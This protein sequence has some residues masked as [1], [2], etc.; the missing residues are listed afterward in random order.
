MARRRTAGTA[1]RKSSAADR[2]S[3]P[4]APIF[5]GLPRGPHGLDPQQVERHQ[6]A[7]LH[8]AMIEAVLASGY[9]GA[10][11][12]QVIGLAGVSRRSFYE[13]FSDK[14]GCYLAT[15]DLIAA[16]IVKRIDDAHRPSGEDLDDLTAA[17]GELAA[18]VV[19]DPKGAN[20]LFVTT[21]TAGAPG[22]MRLHRAMLNIEQVLAS[23]LTDAV[24]PTLPPRPVLRAIVGGLAGIIG[25]WLRKPPSGDPSR[26]TKRLLAWTSLYLSPST[27]SVTQ[28][29]TAGSLASGR[30]GSRI[31]NT[32]QENS[33]ATPSTGERQRLLDRILALAVETDY[34]SLSVVEI[35]DEASV[36]VDTFFE[37]F[38]SKDACF[39]AGLDMVCDQLRSRVGDGSLHDAE[40]PQAV[41]TAIGE[42]LG[43][44]SEHP[45]YT[46]AITTEAPAIVP[47]PLDRHLVLARELAS[48]LIA[49][50]PNNTNRPVVSEG[51][52][53][54]LWHTIQYHVVAG[55]IAQLPTLKNYLSFIVLAPFLGAQPALAFLTE[56]RHVGEPRQISKTSPP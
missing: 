55:K 9:Q 22:L 10:T 43:Y 47:T 15:A 7:R 42:L 12:K 14:Q 26:L 23:C 56:R 30:R 8:L 5:K 13:M 3:N 51:I 1:A 6:R 20:F 33:T 48:L 37:L 25:S 32:T 16:G 39:Q 35:A 29:A 38:E 11:V 34:R 45:T 17:L 27:A 2:G 53:G 49:S 40:W 21:Q 24:D 52:A 28:S 41:L 50:A 18:A 4:Y 36:R 19:G 46:S 54:A 44:L 31:S